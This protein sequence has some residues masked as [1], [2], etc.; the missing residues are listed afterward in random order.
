MEFKLFSESEDYNYDTVYGFVPLGNSKREYKTYLTIDWLNMDEDERGNLIRTSCNCQDYER[1]RR[2]CK[3][4]KECI[5]IVSAGFKFRDEGNLKRYWC[6]I[7]H[8]HCDTGEEK[9]LCY[10][11]KQLLL[12]SNINLNQHIKSGGKENNLTKA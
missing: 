3:H 7:C 10:N 8:G 5:S 6:S 12:E 4:L 11:C 9:P 1:R 2:T